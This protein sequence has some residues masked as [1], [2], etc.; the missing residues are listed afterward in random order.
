MTAWIQTSQ[1]SAEQRVFIQ[2]FLA[3]H[4]WYEFY[5]KSAL[6]ALAAGQDN[7]FYALGRAGEGLIM[8]IAF[9]GIDVFSLVG[10]LDEDEVRWSSNARGA[11]KFTRTPDRLTGS[12]WQEAAMDTDRRSVPPVGRSI[13]PADRLALSLP[14]AHRSRIL[15]LLFM[16]SITRTTCS[17]PGCWS[18]RS[19]VC[20]SVM[21]WW[22][23][24]APSRSSRTI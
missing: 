10:H 5:F 20:S 2:G 4:P 16:V 9:A 15:W 19:S 18:S 6:S 22:R 17:L 23:P 24:P 13:A 14:V 8:G 12:L 7:R 11:P 1:L 21:S 3:D